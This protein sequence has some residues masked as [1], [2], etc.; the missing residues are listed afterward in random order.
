M[1]GI[2]D[3]MTVGMRYEADVLG[4]GRRRAR[5][6]EI[7][8]WG[9]RGVGRLEKMMENVVEREVERDVEGEG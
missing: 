3:G 2:E 1:V 6:V 5:E 8:E 4:G 9:N 7:E